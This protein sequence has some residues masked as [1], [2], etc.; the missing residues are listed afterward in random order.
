MFYLGFLGWTG[1]LSESLLAVHI[2]AEDAPLCPSL[3][4]PFRNGGADITTVAAPARKGASTVAD[5]FSGCSA[6]G[7]CVG[8]LASPHTPVRMRPSTE[9]ALVDGGDRGYV[10]LADKHQVRV[11]WVDVLAYQDESSPHS[12]AQHPE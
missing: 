2:Y 11:N 3:S 1:G 6:Q 9:R 5:A 8:V 12:A 7:N 10:L 4:A